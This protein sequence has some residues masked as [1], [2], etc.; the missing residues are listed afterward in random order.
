MSDAPPTKKHREY[1]SEKVMKVH[2]AG[3]S[4][5]LTP[6]TIDLL[7]DETPIAV[8]LEREPNNRHDRNAIAVRLDRW[9]VGTMVGYVPRDVA[10]KLAPLMDSRTIVISSAWLVKVEPGVAAGDLVIG[11]RKKIS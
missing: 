1:G 8:N 9:R 4:H 7:S 3:M 11:F 2:T 5:H 10:A 6:H